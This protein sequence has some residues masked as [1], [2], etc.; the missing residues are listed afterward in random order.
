MK[1]LLT[2]LCLAS[3]ATTAIAQD[4]LFTALGGAV[5]QM[6]IETCPQNMICVDAFTTHSGANLSLMLPEW[7][8]EPALNSRPEDLQAAA[9]FK[10]LSDGYVVDICNDCDCCLISL[11]EPGNDGFKPWGNAPQALKMGPILELSE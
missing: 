5:V 9:Y 4:T 11:D 8:D 10:G 6:N 1:Y 3:L 2:S 7:V